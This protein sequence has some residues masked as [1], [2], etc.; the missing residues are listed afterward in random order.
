[1]GGLPVLGGARWRPPGTA[2]GAGGTHPT[3]MNSSSNKKSVLILRLLHLPLFT[4]INVDAN[5]SQIHV[6]I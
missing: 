5:I 3:G 1:M 2:T 6:E 4:I